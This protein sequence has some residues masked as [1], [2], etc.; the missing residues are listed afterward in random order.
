MIDHA[1]LHVFLMG[2]AGARGVI[3]RGEEG[4]GRDGA[5][6]GDG[7]RAWYARILDGEVLDPLVGVRE[8]PVT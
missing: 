4:G 1:R 5:H 2:V 3:D 8:L 6:A 7:A